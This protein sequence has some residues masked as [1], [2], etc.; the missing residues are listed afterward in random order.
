MKKNVIAIAQKIGDSETYFLFRKNGEEITF[1][2]IKNIL[3]EYR[4]LTEVERDYINKHYIMNQHELIHK[5]V[6]AP[7]SILDKLNDRYETLMNR[8]SLKVS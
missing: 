8:L 6:N 2:I 4:P 3:I 7:D 5:L 1:K